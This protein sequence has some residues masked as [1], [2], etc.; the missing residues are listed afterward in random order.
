M[1][2]GRHAC[3]GILKDFWLFIL[4]KVWVG[5]VGGLPLALVRRAQ[6][7]SLLL[8]LIAVWKDSFNE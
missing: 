6:A 5:G 2:G 1:E 8:Y 3:N 7:E 4:F